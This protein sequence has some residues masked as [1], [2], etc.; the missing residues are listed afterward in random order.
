MDFNSNEELRVL[1]HSASHV[2][3][4]A[5]KGLF[6]KA[7]LGIGPATDDGFYYDFEVESP[8]TPGDLK[9]IENRMMEIVGDDSPF[10]RKVVNRE[11]ALRIFDDLGENYKVE[12]LQE[13]EDDRVTLYHQ[14]DFVDL[15]KG[16]HIERTGE[17]KVFRLLSV[18]AA[19]WR[20]DEK[21]GSLQRIYGTA[22]AAEEELEQYLKV[23]EEA[24]KRDHRKLGRE[25]ELYSI[26]EEAGAG[27]VYWHPKGTTLRRVIEDFWKDEHIKRGY[28]LVSIPHIARGHLWRTSGHY[29]FYRENMYF[30]NSGEEEY[31]LKP[32]NCPGHI[33]IYQTR[34]RSYRELPIRYAELGTVYRKERTGVLHGMFRVRGFTQDD[35]HIFCTPEQT[36]DEL[37]GVI[38]MAVFML[39]SFG[40]T[41]FEIELSVRGGDTSKYAGSDR[42][43]QMAE[44]GLI[45]AVEAK[46]L[47]YRRVEGE[48]VFYGPKIDIKLLGALRQGWQGPTMQFD[49]NLPERFGVNYIGADGK[50]HPVVM[51]HRTVLGSMERFVGILIEHYGGAFPL[52]LAPV[53]VKVLTISEKHAEYAGEIY[54]QLQNAGIRVGCDNRAEKIGL[55]IR[56]AE[57]QKVP[58]VLIVGDEEV[59]SGEISV[60]QHRKGDCGKSNPVDFLGKLKTEIEGKV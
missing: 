4:Q 27:L 43:W 54:S 60:R 20:G 57:L 31:V 42:D 3:A 39:N 6:P 26:Y 22:F 53:Q 7:K 33:L 30:L 51:I 35:A 44:E 46:S 48:A 47:S 9:R 10:V 32:M 40:F 25:L 21:R 29:E 50:S 15:C 19:Y 14:G 12:L 2:L 41:D 28:E 36:F 37:V 55:K 38:D 34:R 56:E 24:R 23:L 8:F 1:R 49:F 13:I 11:E 18:A 17:L 52:W 59:S 5:V 58:Y 45:K 16:P